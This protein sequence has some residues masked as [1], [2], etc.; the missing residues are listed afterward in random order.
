[1]NNRYERVI[2]MF[3]FRIDKLQ[4]YVDK[5]LGQF[6]E[7]IQ[8]EESSKYLIPFELQKSENLPKGHKYKLNATEIKKLEKR[9]GEKIE[10]IKDE[11][12]T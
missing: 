4:L 7:E 12:S 11:E 8:G 3:I 6:L 1:M 9:Y 2:R 5:V 10:F